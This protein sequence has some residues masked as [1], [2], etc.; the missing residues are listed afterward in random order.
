MTMEPLGGLDGAFLALE[1]NTNHLH[2]AAVM[3]LDP[4]EGRRSLFSSSTRFTQIRRVIEQ[5]IHLVPPLRQR[6]LR[7]PWGLHHPVWVDDPE[8]DLDDH[9]RRASVPE[10]GGRAELD[11]LVADLAGRPLDP[12]RP[13]WEMTV[14]EGLAG[15]RSALVAKLHHAILDGVSGASLLAAFFDLSPRDRPVPLPTPWHPAPLPGKR[16]LL[17]YAVS[18]MARQPA[19]ALDT[20]Q[21]GVETMATLGGHNRRLVDE[22]NAPPPALFSAPRTSL[23]GSISSRRRFASV[24]MPLEDVKLVRQIFGTTVNDVILAGVAGGLRQLFEARGE[25]PDGPLVAMVPVSTRTVSEHSV[26]GNRISGMLVSLATTVDDPVERL[27]AIAEGTKIAKVQEQLTGGRLLADVAQIAP[28]ALASR[29]VRWAAGFG[30]FDRLRPLF[31]VTVSGVKGP[32]RSVFCAGAKMA[33]LVPVGP[34]AEGVGLNVTAM[35]YLDRLGLGL[36]ACRRLVPEV[37][38]LAVMMDDAFAELSAAAWD[39]RAAAG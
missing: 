9:L 6:A 5:R 8:F 3:V 30:L 32:E 4:P 29:A 25:D 7:V 17:G 23:N 2:V 37:D 10:P 28:P 14:V 36:L 15:G 11:E 16:D 38:D 39:A 26:L 21:R 24:S 33:E 13:L 19:A 31:N 12:D 35:S 27:L 20:L 22:G 1:T 18:A 34:I